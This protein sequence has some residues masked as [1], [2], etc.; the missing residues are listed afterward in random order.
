[1]I[2]ARADWMF[3]VEPHFEAG[4]KLIGIGNIYLVQA[5]ELTS[6]LEEL[7]GLADAKAEHDHKLAAAH[8]SLQRAKDAAAAVPK[9]DKV[10]VRLHIEHIGSTVC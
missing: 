8:G 7:E 6:A 2:K 1:V 9:P 4:S 5:D 3:K 10:R